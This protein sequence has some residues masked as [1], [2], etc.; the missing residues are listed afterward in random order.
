[1]IA[2]FERKTE[3]YSELPANGGL[4]GAHGSYQEYIVRLLHAYRYARN[5]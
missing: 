5:R 1:M 3:R 4:A 2:V